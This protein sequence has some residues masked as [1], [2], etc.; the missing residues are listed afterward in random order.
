[1]LVQMRER[2]TRSAAR[3]LMMATAALTGCGG[4]GSASKSP[5]QNAPPLPLAV[6]RARSDN[7]EVNSDIVT[8][9][10]EFGLS[11]LKTLQAQQGRI[12]IAISPLS[13]SIAL[14]ILYNGA[15]GSTQDAIAQTLQLG[16]LT[17]QQVNDANAALQA[18]LV[19]PDPMVE[20]KVA[21]SLWL[22]LDDDGVLPT[23]TQMDQNYYGAMIGDLAGAPGNVNAWVSKETNGLIPDILPPGDYSNVSAV[24]ANAVYFK[25]QWTSTFDPNSTRPAPFTLSDGT[26]ASVKMMYQSGTFAFL[27]GD[28]FQMV[29]LPYGQGRMSMLILLPDSTRSLESFLADIT[30]D[31]LNTMVGQMKS[32]FGDVT[33]PAFK[34]VSNNDMQMVLEALGMAVAFDCSSPADSPQHANFSALTSN[35]VCVENVS[36]NAWIQ[37]D[38]MGTIAAAATTVNVGITAAP[39]RQFAITMDH[40]FLYAIRDDDTGELL[41]IGTLMDPSK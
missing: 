6:A 25:G 4:N 20:L 26:S 22:H 36:H 24:L 27:Q 40:P 5:E 35:H 28:N 32:E 21:N 29:R 39:Q 2:M 12:N 11:V 13:L 1:M 41:F 16:N 15:A 8:A 33:M 3:A 30:V 19:N 23:F 37:V 10:N 18:S 17:R 34:V 38:E 9:D 7:T 31:M 14:Q